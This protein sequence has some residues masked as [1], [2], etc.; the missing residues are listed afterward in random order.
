MRE[1]PGRRMRPCLVATAHPNYGA[2]PRRRRRRQGRSA[3]RGRPAPHPTAFRGAWRRALA[4][5]LAWVGPFVRFRVSPGAATTPPPAR[6]ACAAARPP[7]AN[8]PARGSRA[9][10]RGLPPARPRL[11]SVPKGQPPRQGDPEGS[12]GS[13]RPGAARRASG[14]SA[15]RI[16]RTRRRVAQFRLA[17]P[18]RSTDPTR[19]ATGSPP[20]RGTGRRRMDS[21]QPRRRHFPA[22]ATPLRRGQALPRRGA[23]FPHP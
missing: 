6:T 21:F 23:E 7:V 3:S 20:R 5:V 8:K 17:A 14:R 10:P 9:A 18:T 22:P 19:A 15:R 13:C 12:L 4:S 1:P 16:R 11:R 2:S